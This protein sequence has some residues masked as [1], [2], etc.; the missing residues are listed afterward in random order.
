[1]PR[2]GV[3]FKRP[4]S[5]VYSYEAEDAEKTWFRRVR[6]P[7]RKG[8]AVG[9][10]IP[11][12]PVP[13]KNEGSFEIKKIVSVLDPE[14]LIREKEVELARWI[15][16]YYF[17]SLG[18]ALSLFFPFG[19]KPPA[20][21]PRVKAEEKVDSSE[22]ISANY[23]PSEEQ[24]KILEQMAADRKAGK[25]VGLLQGVTGSGKTLVY[26][27]L[28]R[29]VA[30]EGKQVILTLPEI[31][32]TPQTLRFFSE[33]IGGKIAV[34]H[35]RKSESEKY[36]DWQAI[37]RGEVPLILG[38]RSALFAPAKNL[39]AIII[40]EE[41]ESTYKQNAVPRYHAR[42][43]AQ[44]RARREKAFL[45]MGSAT[46]SVETFY[47]AKSGAFPLYELKRRFHESEPPLDAVAKPSRI[48][49]LLIPEPVLDEMKAAVQR[50]EQVLVYL[51]KR[52]Y[53]RSR[54]CRECGYFD[55]CP[56]CSVSMTLHKSAR[57]LRCHCCGHVEPEK[58]LC[59]RCGNRDMEERSYGTERLEEELASRLPGISVGRLD[60]EVMRGEGKKTNHLKDF[61]SGKLQI[62]LGTQILTKG[63]DFAR[64]S[65]VVIVEPEGLLAFPDFRAN[66][67][68]FA[69]IAQ[70]SGRAGRRGKRGRVILIT[71]LTDSFAIDFGKKQ[72]YAG[73]YEKEIE[74]RR[75]FGYP[76]F[77]K[78]LR[79]V[80]RGKKSADVA[81]EALG[82][83]AEL[84]TC[85]G[86]SAE[87][88]GPSPC[89]IEKIKYY[90][91]WHL[92]LKVAD[93]DRFQAGMARFREGRRSFRDN[94]LEYDMDPYD[95]I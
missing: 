18:E 58:G 83:R 66:E 24:K 70:V 28:I 67:R 32:L 6:V 11:E 27:E 87:I 92:V 59:P 15:A 7:L 9:Y 65:L 42:Q 61:H 43:V 74:N 40:D 81:T 82:I 35:S 50:S 4:L 55:L 64:V 69:Q 60:S 84:E 72:D 53:A 21:K 12:V 91:R 39:G 14:P 62:L 30:A 80:L 56:R 29:S 8:T 10:A 71:S 51:N 95:M 23:T 3:V 68:T 17:S 37:Y 5:Q 33:V 25:Q 47:Q 93:F 86:D 19:E 45:L 57:E 89:L 63:H 41:H 38:A 36:R 49:T 54:V 76:P 75:S 52:G 1:M 88:L 79:L 16:R 22:M 20:K 44:I 13:D 73:F 46:P 31:A 94:Y 48:Q 85:L 77:K 26:A 78:I 2:V 34:I 90:F